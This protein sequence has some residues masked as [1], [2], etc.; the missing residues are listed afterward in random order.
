MAVEILKQYLIKKSHV[1][2]LQ[3]INCW[4]DF[5]EVTSSEENTQEAQEVECNK[6]VSCWFM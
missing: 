2:L 3:I 4:F 1:I 6:Q 5:E